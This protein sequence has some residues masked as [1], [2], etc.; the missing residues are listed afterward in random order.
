MRRAAALL[1]AGV[2][3]SAAA[4]AEELVG[5]RPDFTESAVTVGAGRVQLEAGATLTEAGRVTELTAGEALLRLGIGERW[6]LRLG[7]NSYARVDLLGGA[8][9]EGFEDPSL[10]AK[11]ALLD[12]GDGGTA[13][14][15]LFGS[16]IGV[17]D[18]E[19]G[20][21]EEQPEVKLL[22]GVPLAGQAELGV[23]VGYARPVDGGR[24]FGQLVASVAAA[25]PVADRVGVFVEVYGFSREAPGGPESTYFDGGVTFA[26][27]P[28]LQLDARAGTGLSGN[29]VD[30]F[31]GA[32]V[33]RRW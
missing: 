6:E 18:D 26:L 17:G 11:L 33:V 3:T 24:R 21:D 7:L 12:P 9:L 19:V 4:G 16:S 23:N 31:L 28:D 8:E 25:W 20:S 27:G 1:V 13:L 2:L 30:L 32:G 10:G 15:L 14:A 29:D 5:D 22:L